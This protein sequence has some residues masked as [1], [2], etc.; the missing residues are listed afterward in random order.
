MRVGVIGLGAMGSRVA[1]NFL[2]AGHDVT[3][4]NRSTYAV[5]ALVA[6]GAKRANDVSD[7]LQGDVALTILFDD[8]AV[9]TTLL[10][11]GSLARAAKACIHVCMATISMAF[12]HELADLHAALGLRYAAAPMLGRPEVIEKKGLNILAA[13]E[14]SILDVL[15]APF[16]ELGK[17]WRLGPQPTDANIGKLAANFM[18]AGA[19]E[20]MAEAAALVSASGANAE[21]FLSTMSATLFSAPIYRVYGPMIAGH[22]PA[23][24]SGLSMPL[25][26]IGNTL[27]AA[28]RAAI[29]MPLA[30]TIKINLTRASEAGG[31]DQDWATAFAQTALTRRPNPKTIEMKR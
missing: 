26:D 21:H 24:P 17:M 11:S 8:N 5:D 13:G 22:V 12:A 7:A 4:W 15:E 29:T 31:A 30:E 28:K 6:A 27:A 25:K 19:L 9:R 16:A 1:R 23:A 2:A 10:E 14:A 3:V 18:I 20:A